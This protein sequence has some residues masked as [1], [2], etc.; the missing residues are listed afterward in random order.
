MLMLGLLPITVLIFGRIAFAAPAVNL[1]AVP[2]F[3]IVT[4]PLALLGLL[5]DGPLQ[6]VGNQALSIAA[7]SVGLIEYLI[8]PVAAQSW[9]AHPYLT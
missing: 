4:V 2:L 1:V 5:L 3:S 8:A 6:S 9:A 7:R